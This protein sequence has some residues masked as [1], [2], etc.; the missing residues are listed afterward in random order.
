ME[1]LHCSASAPPMGR[2]RAYI[3]FH[4]LQVSMEMHYLTGSYAPAKGLWMPM[5]GFLDAKGKR[6]Q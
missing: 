5:I 6:Y 2:G 4:P 3:A 1:I